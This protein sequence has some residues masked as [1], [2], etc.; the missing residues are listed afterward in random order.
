M[1]QRLLGVLVFLMYRL[2]SMTWRMQIIEPVSLKENC[3]NQKTVLLAHWHGDELS[4]LKLTPVYRVA[5][6]TSTSK[7]GEIMNTALRLFGIKT[8]RGS[9][10]RGGS[11]ALR[12]LVRILKNERRNSS[13][14][15]DGPKGPLHKAKPGIFEISRLLQAPIYPAGVSCDRAWRFPKSWNQAYLPKPFARLIVFWGEAL[16]PVLPEEDP[17]DA[18]LAETL[19]NALHYARAQAQKNLAGTFAG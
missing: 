1:K 11:S 18:K 12:G 2:L 6:I 15:V 17:R 10:T 5:T 9:S 13:L 19:E 14:A 16:P 4:L 7:D 8:A 3:K